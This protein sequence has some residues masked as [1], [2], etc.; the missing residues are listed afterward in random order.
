MLCQF[1]EKCASK[2]TQTEEKTRIGPKLERGRTGAGAGGQL[3]HG[4]RP[5]SVEEAG[6]A[7]SGLGRLELALEAEGE[8]GGAR[9]T[10]DAG[11]RA[12]RPG[13]RGWNGG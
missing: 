12:P 7:G 13:S 3:T 1:C 5:G 6:Q 2:E 10:R 11:K 8:A 4:L 9:S